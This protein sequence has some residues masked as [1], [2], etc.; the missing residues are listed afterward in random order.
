MTLGTIDS[1]PDFSS[2]F[3]PPRMVEI[4]L[5]PNYDSER[6]DGYPVLY[7]H[8][9]QNLFQPSQMSGADWGI[10]EA[11]VKLVDAGEMPPVIVVGIASLPTRWEE[12]MPAKAF[13]L[14]RA[15]ALREEWADKLV[16]RP[17]S[18]D[19]LNFVVKELK[20]FVDARYNTAPERPST[21]LMGSSMGGLISLYAISEYPDVF[22][23]AGCLST[24]W[25]V[26]DGAMVDYM[27]IALPTPKQHKIYFDFG[28]VDLD[29]EYEPF[30]MEADAVMREQGFTEGKDWL[31][32]KFVGATHSEQAW[33]ERLHIP[34]KFLLT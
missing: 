4:W 31:T 10:R 33:R 25:V 32:K 20:P 34:L 1:Y 27:K 6:S 19:Y 14:P 11:I 22:G 15:E 24:H 3:V 28:T 29:A 5:P 26:G 17:F 23:G 18:D 16:T 12:Y 8:D 9:G 13:Y 21:F 2:Q 7:M 30:Q